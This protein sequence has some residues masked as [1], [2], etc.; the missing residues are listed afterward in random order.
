MIRFVKCGNG[1]MAPMSITCKHLLQG[2]ADVWCEL[3]P[4]PGGET[5]DYICIM[6]AMRGG[7]SKILKD[8]LT[9][10]CMHC[11]QDIINERSITTIPIAQII[12]GL[13]S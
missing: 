9:V 1:H 12:A 13:K 2:I 6:C 7:L 3:G 10:L 5:H 11:V 4:K 8:D